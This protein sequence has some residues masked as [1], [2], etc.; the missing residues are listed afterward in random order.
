MRLK[1]YTLLKETTNWST[2]VANGVYIT[3]DKP[4]GRTFKSIGYISPLTDEVKWF[5]NGLNIDTRGRTFKE[6]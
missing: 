6:V 5:S 4:K 3:L 1:R 2:L